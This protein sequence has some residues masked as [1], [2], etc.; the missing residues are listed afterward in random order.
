MNIMVKLSAL[1]STDKVGKLNQVMKLVCQFCESWSV[2]IETYCSTPDDS[3]SRYKR[4]QID[5]TYSVS[6][7]EA[8]LLFFTLCHV[9]R[10]IKAR[11]PNLRFRLIDREGV[12]LDDTLVDEQG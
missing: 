9:V 8:S 3:K 10:N 11:L 2:G 4:G 5:L 6:Q 12:V 1:I 7:E